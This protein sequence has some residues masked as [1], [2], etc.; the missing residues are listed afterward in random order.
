MGNQTENTVA[1]KYRNR[2]RRAADKGNF[3]TVC[4]VSNDN[5]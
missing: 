2:E 5:R 3:Y 1:C 4:T